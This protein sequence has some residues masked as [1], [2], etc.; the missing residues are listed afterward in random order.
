MFLKPTYC[1][2]IL[3]K[4][5]SYFYPLIITSL[6]KDFSLLVLLDGLHKLQLVE[7]SEQGRLSPN[8]EG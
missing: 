1:A 2:M 4:I 5:Q 6:P 8:L 3:S 7:C